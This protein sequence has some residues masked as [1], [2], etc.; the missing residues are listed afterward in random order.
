MVIRDTLFEHTGIHKKTW[1]SPTSKLDHVLINFEW[2]RC[3]QDVRVFRSADVAS[4]HFLIVSKIKTKL[5][6]K[7]NCTNSSTRPWI[8]ALLGIEKK[9]DEF[10]LELANRFLPLENEQEDAQGPWATAKS[11]YASAANRALVRT[12]TR[13]S[14]K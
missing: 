1:R 7:R 2:K 5:S 12:S 6:T 13:R 14:A 3:L 8:M 11:C 9:K 4:D 10:V